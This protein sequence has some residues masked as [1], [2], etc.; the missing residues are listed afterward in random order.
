MDPR[1]GGPAFALLGLASAQTLVEAEVVVISGYRAGD[2]PALSNKLIAAG[3]KVKI[4]GP[5]VGPLKWSP[6]MRKEVESAVRWAEIVHIHGIWEQILHVACRASISAS[7]PYI[8]R[9][10]GMLDPWSLS[11][12]RLRKKVML[13]WR[14]GRNM[15]NAAAFHFTTQT[16]ADLA[17]P[18]QHSERSIVEP[19]GVEIALKQDRETARRGIDLHFPKLPN[20]PLLLFC[21]RIHPKKGLIL[22]VEAFAEIVRNWDLPSA[23]P[24]LIIAGPDEN[25]YRAMVEEKVKTK[26]LAEYVYFAGPVSG[27]HKSMLFAGSDLFCL[28]SYQENFGIAVAEAASF[29]MPVLVS[30]QVNIHS[31][32]TLHNAGGVTSLNPTMIVQELAKWVQNKNMRELSG[33]NAEAWSKSR[34]NWSAIAGRWVGIHYPRLIFANQ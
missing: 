22:L 2:D 19:N 14:V 10:C 30:D 15:K 6:D 7:T 20:G 27:R 9:P 25:G 17:S 16:E 8:I 28:I 12:S 31:E 26:G 24:A 29:G 21:S 23:L 18:F 33:R 13:N 5:C 3:V 32:V 1:S 11:Q 4:V 34:F